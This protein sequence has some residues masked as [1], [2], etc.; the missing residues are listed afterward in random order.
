MHPVDRT[1]PQE[2][3]AFTSPGGL[4]ADRRRTRSTSEWVG[5]RVL[6]RLFYAAC[7]WG[8]PL[9]IRNTWLRVRRRTRYTVLLYHRVNDVSTDKLTTS[10]TRFIQHLSL[11]RR[12]YPVMSLIEATTGPPERYRG[13]NVVIITFD[14][15]YAD[16]AEVAAPILQQFG[17]S[18]TFF[19]CAGLMGT[20]QTFPHDGR[21]PHRFKNLSWDQVRMLHAS[22]FEIGSHGW[23][24][25][26]LGRL[27]LEEAKREVAMSLQVLREKLGRSPRCFAYPFGG[28]DDIS[29]QVRDYIQEIGFDLIASAYGGTN[30]GRIDPQNVLRVGASDSYSTLDLRAQ[31]EGVSLGALRMR[32]STW[33]LRWSRERG[34]RKRLFD[35]WRNSDLAE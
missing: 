28:I 29:D 20:T 8:G 7:L 1:I 18:A 9:W 34:T 19:V 3:D 25:G 4:S 24:H 15:G 16:N 17:C 11:I 6:K 35:G 22:G 23:S 5:K 31:I 27:P 26:N 14:D 10:V 32:V 12:H 21:S 33:P 2:L 30:V 13:P